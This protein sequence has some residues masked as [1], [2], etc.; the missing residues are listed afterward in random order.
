MSPRKRDNYQHRRLFKPKAKE[1]KHELKPS[2]QQKKNSEGQ[3]FSERNMAGTIIATSAAIYDKWHH[4]YRIIVGKEI[5]KTYC[6][7]RGTAL[8]PI[9]MPVALAAFDNVMV[10]AD[11][12]A[13][14]K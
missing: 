6:L 13:N 8:Q 1:G 5:L 2:H 4:L 12:R 10:N 9:Q 3:F 14:C 7:T 11:Y